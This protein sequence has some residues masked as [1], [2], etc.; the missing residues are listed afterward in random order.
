MT[1]TPWVSRYSSVRSRSRIDFAPAQTTRTGER[2]N[3]VRSAE[4]SI[5]DC[6]PRWT[7]PMPPVA[8]KRMPAMLAQSIV[9]ATVVAPNCFVARVIARSRLLTFCTFCAVPKRVICS[10]VRP[11][12][13]CPS[14]MPM[15]AGMAPSARMVDSMAWAT[16]MLAGYGRPC[17]M[18]VDSRATTGCCACKAV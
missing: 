6:A 16:S 5:V 14:C 8:K 1:G 13:I 17:A 3:S 12:L 11:M 7:P 10:S 4:I 18:T 2:L 9:P 15:V